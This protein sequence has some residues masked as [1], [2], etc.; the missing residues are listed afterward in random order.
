VIASLGFF[1]VPMISGMVELHLFRSVGHYF[2]LANLA[3][4][5]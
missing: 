4:A 1:K 5:V 3:D 2:Q